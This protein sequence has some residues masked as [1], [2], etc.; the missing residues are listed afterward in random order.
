MREKQ[1]PL[2]STCTGIIFGRDESKLDSVTAQNGPRWQSSAR[3]QEERKS[4]FPFPLTAGKLLLPQ[5][6][7]TLLWGLSGQLDLV[8]QGE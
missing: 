6:Q 8:V 5:G 1:Q 3:A 4:P 2:D 7:K